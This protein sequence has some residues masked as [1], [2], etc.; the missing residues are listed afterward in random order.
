MTE[1]K[2]PEPS[3]KEQVKKLSVLEK[4]RQKVDV[5]LGLKDKPEGSGIKSEQAKKR[6][7]KLKRSKKYL[8][9][10]RRGVLIFAVLTLVYLFMRYS[11][12]SFSTFVSEF[13][14]DDKV[15]IDEFI[16]DFPFI[17]ESLSIEDKVMFFTKPDRTA[18]SVGRIYAKAGDKVE[19]EE[20]Q[21]LYFF[22]LGGK[23][24][25]NIPA[26]DAEEAK[27]CRGIVPKGH[28][29]VIDD[30]DLGKIFT[31]FD[32]RQAGFIP[33]ENIFARLVLVWS[34]ASKTG[35]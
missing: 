16:G 8:S 13:Q 32:S 22:K 3:G 25:R 24:Q 9:W 18:V 10:F 11:F 15:L 27:N 20:V 21:G 2:K 14:K 33:R 5:D 1:D 26:L 17:Q 30:T 29:L 34:Q 7:Q 12:Y 35:E 4:A 6:M 19:F 23:I 31:L 28:Y